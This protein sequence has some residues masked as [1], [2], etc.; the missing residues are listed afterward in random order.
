MSKHRN[1]NRNRYNEFQRNGPI[2]N[3]PFGINPNQLLNLLGSNFN[4]NG[5][6]SLLNSMNM[7]GFDFN[8]MNNISN[9]SNANNK[10][11]K[12]EET[13]S[14]KDE[15]IQLIIYLKSIVDPKRIPFLDKIIEL[16]ENGSFEEKIKNNE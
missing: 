2:N 1:R 9:F 4:M 10:T 5:L 11:N 13:T 7:D 16:Y 12:N 8:S 6:G 14:Y 3:S 15:D